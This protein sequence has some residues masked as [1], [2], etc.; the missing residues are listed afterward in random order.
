MASNVINLGV[1]HIGIDSIQ[2]RK[3]MTD[4]SNESFKVGD[5]VVVTDA[6]G[7]LYEIAAIRWGC[8]P[9]TGGIADLRFW[10]IAPGVSKLI[11]DA[12]S[13]R[14]L[15]ND[16]FGSYLKDLHYPDNELEVIAISAQ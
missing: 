6:P 2:E 11:R 16:L 4:G 5:L 13:A 1:D 15:K 14:D 10:G 7:V 8:P 12:L 9:S 3:L